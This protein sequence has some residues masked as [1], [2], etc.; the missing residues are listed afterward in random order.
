MTFITFRVVTADW[1]GAA[2]CASL[3]EQFQCH[4]PR[5]RR[6][7]IVAGAAHV[8]RVLGDARTRWRPSRYGESEGCYVVAATRAVHIG[9]AGTGPVVA[10]Y[11]RP[12]WSAW[13]GCL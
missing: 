9:T 8:G 5:P 4:P 12:F 3:N 13:R 10:R 6:G 1:C 7:R 2:A 11:G